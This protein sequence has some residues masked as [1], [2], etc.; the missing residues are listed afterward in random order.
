MYIMKTQISSLLIFIL[1][2]I[3]FSCGEDESATQQL[4]K[5]DPKSVSSQSA[6][7]VR[8]IGYF[9]ATDECDSAGEGATYAIWMTGDLEGCFYIFV[10]SYSCTPSGA[11]KEIGREYFDGTYHGE[12]GSFWTTYKFEAKYEGCAPDGSYIG[13]EIFGRCQHPIVEGSGEGAFEGVVGRLDMKDDIDAG[14]Y[15]YRG[16]FSL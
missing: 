5:S 12:A 10:D 1:A 16:H 14:N 4:K 11:Y 9:D 7:Q 8:G 15:P 3:V 6:D 13:A 2:L